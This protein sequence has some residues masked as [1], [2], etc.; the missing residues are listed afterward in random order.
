MRQGGGPG[1]EDVW[2]WMHSRIRVFVWA[3]VTLR[4]SGYL[5]ACVH[6]G[7]SGGKSR[8]GP[9]LLTQLTLYC[10]GEP[11]AVSWSATSEAVST[12]VTNEKPSCTCTCTLVLTCMRC[13]LMPA[14]WLSCCSD[15]RCLMSS[16]CWSMFCN[17][18]LSVSVCRVLRYAG[19]DAGM[20]WSLFSLPW[21]QFL[22][23]LWSSHLYLYF[24]C[25]SLPLF[26]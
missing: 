21:L 11:Y 12:S 4:G 15:S 24:H 7:V 17:L 23:Q 3:H 14:N 1:G 10:G 13:K 19:E 6:V 25:F 16:R 20:K 26:G 5:S 2:M 8:P 22:S 18:L 9:A